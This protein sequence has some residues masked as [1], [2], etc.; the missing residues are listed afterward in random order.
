MPSWALGSYITLCS[1]VPGTLVTPAPSPKQSFKTRLLH[2]YHWAWLWWDGRSDI[3]ATTLS[4]H[5]AQSLHQDHHL[6]VHVMWHSGL[7]GALENCQQNLH[8]FLLTMSLVTSLSQSNFLCGWFSLSPALVEV[9]SSLAY[10]RHYDLCCPASRC[11]SESLD[12][13]K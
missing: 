6:L 10:V 8:P 11:V 4:F 1:G 5:H 13:Q 12:R 7:P 2:H 3:L 9:A